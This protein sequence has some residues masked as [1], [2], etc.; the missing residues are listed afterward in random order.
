MPDSKIVVEGKL[1][2]AAKVAKDGY[3][4]LLCVDDT[5]VSGMMNKINVSMSN[6]LP[7]STE[8]FLKT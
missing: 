1:A 8:K 7:D 3:E 6:V 5:I 2:Y 4:A